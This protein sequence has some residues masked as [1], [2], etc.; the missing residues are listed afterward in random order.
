MFL[1]MCIWSI[2]VT[3]LGT[4]QGLEI[5]LV[6]V[7]HET[8]ICKGSGSSLWFG[9][10]VSQ[11]IYIMQRV[12]SY[13]QGYEVVCLKWFQ[14]AM[15]LIQLLQ[16]KVKFKSSACINLKLLVIWLVEDRVTSTINLFSSMIHWNCCTT[17]VMMEEAD[18]VILKAIKVP[19]PLKDN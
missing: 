16:V 9:I 3:P 12:R 14:L 4:Q 5:H 18:H 11:D 2:S 17:I 6:C 1:V 10:W 15:D 13:R 19:V 8:I 7:F